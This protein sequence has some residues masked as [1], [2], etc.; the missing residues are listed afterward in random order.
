[1]RSQQEW[2]GHITGIRP[3]EARN[4]FDYLKYIYS[5]AIFLSSLSSIF[6]YLFCICECELYYL[7]LRFTLL[8]LYFKA[9]RYEVRIQ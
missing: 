4:E 5:K 3:S 6:V 8:I 7:Y 2:K 9:T 1:M